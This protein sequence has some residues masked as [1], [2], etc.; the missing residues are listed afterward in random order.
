MIEPAPSQNERGRDC[1]NRPERRPRVSAWRLG[2]MLLLGGFCC[3]QSARADAI[4]AG[5]EAYAHRDYVRSAAIF[6]RRAER[7]Q[8]IAQTYLG[9]MYEKGRGVPQDFVVAATWLRRAANQGYPDAQFLLG[10]LY[11][12]GHGV[13]QD[14]LEAEIWLNLAAAKAEPR[15]RDYWTQVRDA[16]AGKLTLDER[17]EAQKRAS[18][19]A[20]VQER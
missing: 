4:N 13:N 3:V 9:Y 15:Q 7:G 19:W 14:F 12:K 6:M 2:A 20:P 18:E 17:A 5:M 8:A 11:D 16:L 10:L 1:K